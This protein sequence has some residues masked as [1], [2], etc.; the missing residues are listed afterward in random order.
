MSTKIIFWNCALG[1]KSKLEYIRD[2][3]ATERPQAMFIS[4][5]EVMEKD[6]NLLNIRGYELCVAATI[7]GEFAVARAACF[8]RSDLKFKQIKTDPKLDIVALDIGENRLIG[9]YKGFKLPTGFTKKTYTNF[10]LNKLA[11]LSRSNKNVCIGGDFNIDISK[12]CPASED[13]ETWAIDAGLIQLVDQVTRQRA[14][15]LE[16]GQIRI[17]KSVIDHVY[18]NWL[19]SEINYVNSISD[20]M[21]LIVQLVNLKLPGTTKEGFLVRD[22]R[23]YQ[24]SEVH[25]ILLGAK[26]QMSIQSFNDLSIVLRN[27]LDQVAPM[28]MVKVREKQLVNT[29]IDAIKKRRDRFLKKYKNSRNPEHLAKA[30]SFTKTLKKVV[31]KEAR[32]TFQLKAVSPNPKNFWQTFNFAL[33]GFNSPITMITMNGKDEKDALVLSNAFANFF[34]DKITK[35]CNGE[36]DYCVPEKPEAP[37]RF[38]IVEL[39]EAIKTMSNKKSFGL[40]GITQNFFRTSMQVLDHE[41]LEVLNEFARNG[42][43]TSLKTARVIPLH[44]KG[45]K[46]DLNN[47]R[48]V[49]NLSVFSKVYE[50]CL[51][52][53]LESEL[54]NVEGE[55]QH[56]YR[57]SHSTETALLTIQAVMSETLDENHQGRLYSVDLSAAFDLLRPDKFYNMFRNRISEGLMFALMDF[58][59]ERSFVVELD[60]KQS[61]KINLDR[62]C[63]QGSILG[64]K[65]FTLYTHELANELGDVKVVTYADD[66]YV[67]ITGESIDEIKRKANITFERHVNYLTK[68]GMV[69]NKSKTEVLWIGKEKAIEDIELNNLKL[70]VADNIKALGIMISGNLNWD[71]HANLALEKGKKLMSSFSFLRKYLTRDQFLKAHFYGAVFYATVVWFDRCKERFKTKFKSLHYRLLRTAC[72][73]YH[74]SKSKF[75]LTKIC[76]WANPIE[77]NKF[78]TA[79]KVVKI[80]R[81]QMP[82]PL[83]D[84]LDKTLYVEPRKPGFGKFFDSSKTKWGYQSIQN[85]MA[86]M[87][88]VKDDWMERH[89]SDDAIRILM[90]NSFFG[91]FN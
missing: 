22:W 71:A 20:H 33:G 18:T 41:S 5:S 56:A 83:F 64:P 74:F 50:K 15:C 69:V 10:F 85:R 36:I 79:S 58:L 29:K 14:V 54:R 8:V 84:L 23:N 81:D 40:D 66:T 44:K 46:T 90:K 21:I 16:N 57:K 6:V 89:I 28:R 9:I 43:D 51:L 37:I 3:L 65:L 35:L 75:E 60:K 25:D 42:L 13:L 59:T 26:D 27:T 1:I 4:E 76:N 82:K 32:R 49:S 38:N 67:I 12:N 78:A 34:G 87:G 61:N 17:E 72:K 19:D 70:K 68:I 88:E 31:K 55:H 91:Y 53:R 7:K 45:D 11:F 39:R 73:D 63:V 48:P 80:V 52:M 2:L 86:M 24:A 47:Y 30:K 77:W 62:G